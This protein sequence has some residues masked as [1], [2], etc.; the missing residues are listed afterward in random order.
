MA[1]GRFPVDHVVPA[2]QGELRPKPDQVRKYAAGQALRLARIIGQSDEYHR[3]RERADL[4]CLVTL[5]E[6]YD[7]THAPPPVEPQ[8]PPPIVLGASDDEVLAAINDY[9]KG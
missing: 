9:F 2:L 8:A 4:A 1:R 6:S 7:S 5:I 3:R